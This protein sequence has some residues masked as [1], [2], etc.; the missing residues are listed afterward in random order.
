M[1]LHHCFLPNKTY[2]CIFTSSKL[3]SLASL[4]PLRKLSLTSHNFISFQNI[5]PQ[6][7][8]INVVSDNF[9]FWA[10][11]SSLYNTLSFANNFST[12]VCI[13]LSKAILQ[14]GFPLLINLYSPRQILKE[15]N[16]LLVFE[17]FYS[18]VLSLFPLIFMFSFGIQYTIV[19]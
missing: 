2:A 8:T 11:W 17:F 19:P 3:F 12:I 15:T 4:F 6:S 16:W 14:G 5:S 9:N 7:R 10:F 18:C 13:G 1:Y